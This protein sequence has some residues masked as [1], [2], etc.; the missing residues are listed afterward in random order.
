[1]TR[2]WSLLVRDQDILDLLGTC[3]AHTLYPLAARFVAIHDAIKKNDIAAI[4]KI[5]KESRA[6]GFRKVVA[7]IK[8]GMARGD[9]WSAGY[10]ARAVIAEAFRYTPAYFQALDAFKA[11]VRGRGS[12]ISGRRSGRTSKR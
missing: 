1:M 2:D 7:A 3:N 4:N 9:G 5:E 10:T 11:V 12:G 8:R 6:A